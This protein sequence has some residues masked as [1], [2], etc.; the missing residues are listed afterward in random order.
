LGIAAA[1]ER[2]E[3]EKRK[4]RDEKSGNID[5]QTAFSPSLPAALPSTFLL[6]GITGSGKTELYLRAIGRALL[7]RSRRT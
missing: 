3:E 2:A 1:I 4:Q 5:D 6:H 7:R